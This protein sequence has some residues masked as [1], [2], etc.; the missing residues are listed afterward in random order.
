MIAYGYVF[1]PPLI[2]C[3]LRMHDVLEDMSDAELALLPGEIV[4][5][6]RERRKNKPFSV[7]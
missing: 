6:E 4:G 7:D 5:R 3:A 1:E 2:A